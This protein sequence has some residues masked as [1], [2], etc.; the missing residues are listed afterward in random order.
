MNTPNTAEIKIGTRVY[1][2]LY[3]GRHGTVYAIKGELQAHNVRSLGG[4]IVMTGGNAELAIVFD[5]GTLSRVPE[6][7]VRG[8]QWRI[9]AEVE[10]AEQIALRLAHAET[11]KAEKETAEANAKAAHAAAM[12]ALRTD[13]QYSKLEQGSDGSGKLAG[14]NL[15][16][17]LKAKWPA[18]KFTVR[19]SSYGTVYISWTDGPT[20]DQ[21]EAIANQFKEGHFDGM[22]DCYKYEPNP[23][24][25]VFGGAKYLMTSRDH[26]AELIGKAIAV[27][28]ENYAGNFKGEP[29][30]TVAQYQSGELVRCHV[31]GLIDS[32]QTLITRQLATI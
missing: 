12:E 8:V 14:A 17:L 28:L 6:C 30:P 18:V 23:F 16:K 2:T 24:A 22:D 31:D 20:V 26:S 1:S 19:K 3:G 29:T 9:S 13:P 4:G 7:I 32:V 11:V 5:N 10:S 27:V 15:R 25:E 21:V